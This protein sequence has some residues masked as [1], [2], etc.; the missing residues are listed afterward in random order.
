MHIVGCRVDRQAVMAATIDELDRERPDRVR[1]E[2]PT[3]RVG[4]QEEVD[5]GM[6]E[7]G[8][9][10]LDRL[11][12]ADDPAVVL[13]DEGQVGGLTVD[14]VIE[15]AFEVK[16]APPAGDLRLGQDRR[17][18]GRILGRGRSQSD[19]ASAQLHAPDGTR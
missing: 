6:A 2:S 3:L 18:G 19:L 14:E 7:V 13:D 9:E 8:L 12:V 10:L 17:Q 5:A 16:V 15:D 11:D 1:A 4:A